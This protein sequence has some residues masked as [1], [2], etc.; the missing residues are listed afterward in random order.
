MFLELHS[1][2]LIAVTMDT[3]P[4]RKKNNSADVAAAMLVCSLAAV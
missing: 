3:A 4:C 1:P 2:E